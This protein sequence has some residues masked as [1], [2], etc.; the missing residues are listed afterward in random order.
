MAL[1][2]AKLAT[3]FSKA[4]ISAF[5]VPALFFSRFMSNSFTSQHPSGMFHKSAHTDPTAKIEIGALV[6][7]EFIVGAND[8]VGLGS[9]VGPAVTTGQSTRTGYSQ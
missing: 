9:V 3:F 4:Y 7:S 1:R 8:C 6:H 2:A 5:N